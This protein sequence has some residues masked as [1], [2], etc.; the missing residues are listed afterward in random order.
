MRQGSIIDG[1]GRF[2]C[3]IR[4]SARVGRP[5]VPTHRAFAPKCLFEEIRR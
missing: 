1:I 2:M 4:F 3:I 5:E